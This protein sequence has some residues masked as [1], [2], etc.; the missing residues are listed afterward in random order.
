MPA[1]P[2]EF[3]RLVPAEVYAAD[4]S[5]EFA[6]GIGGLT[7]TDSPDPLVEAIRRQVANP[8]SFVVNELI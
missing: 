5:G 2:H 4:W 1:N 6:N 3:S 7:D 8:H